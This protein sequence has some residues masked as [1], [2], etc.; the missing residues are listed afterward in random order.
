[1]I[2]NLNPRPPEA[3]ESLPKSKYWRRTSSRRHLNQFGLTPQVIL[4]TIADPTDV[5]K[6]DGA[7]GRFREFYRYFEPGDERIVG[8]S[9]AVWGAWFRVVIDPRGSL[10]TAFLDHFTELQG[11]RDVCWTPATTRNF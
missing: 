10:Y 3:F 11:G 1:M 8:V 2:A 7:I 6:Q 4:E 9:D 5:Q